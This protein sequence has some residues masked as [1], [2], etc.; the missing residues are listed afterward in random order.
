MEIDGEG[1]GLGAISVS[2]VE[3]QYL[4]TI[5]EDGDQMTGF[6]E[7][8]VEQTV[9]ALTNTIPVNKVSLTA[10]G[11][12]KAFPPERRNAIALCEAIIAASGQTDFLP[13]ELR[14]KIELLVTLLSPATMSMEILT[15]R[16]DRL[17]AYEAED[18]QDR[19]GGAILDF[20][21]LQPLGM[22]LWGGAVAF[23]D[24]NE[25]QILKQRAGAAIKAK[26]DKSFSDLTIVTV[27]DQISQRLDDV[28]SAM[29][30]GHDALKTKKSDGGYEKETRESIAASLEQCSKNLQ[31]GLS[32]RFT[33]AVEQAL[34]TI[35][36]AL[37]NNGMAFAE[38]AGEDAPLLNLGATYMYIP[39][40]RSSLHPHI[41]FVRY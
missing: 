11:Q 37:S 9:L 23:F 6:A 16:M 26:I 35:Q 10:A 4:E 24:A 12:M 36:Y 28:R 8:Q 20:I 15:E 25:Y 13:R 38:D 1:G 30:E 41:P 39:Y 19:T 17:K 32:K 21:F 31:Q 34:G 3:V 2:G 22:A 7:M 5:I 14:P 18:E 33:T 40:R 27:S 29:Q